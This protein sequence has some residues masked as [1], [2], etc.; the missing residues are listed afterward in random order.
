MADKKVFDGETERIASGHVHFLKTADGVFP[1]H[2]ILLHS[3]SMVGVWHD[4]VCITVVSRRVCTHGCR[5]CTAD[6]TFINITSL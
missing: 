5:V 1:Q 2:R 3:D 6:P 4:L